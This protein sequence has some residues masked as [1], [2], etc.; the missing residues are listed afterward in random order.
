M[1]IV[2]FALNAIS[3]ITVRGIAHIK[4]DDKTDC[5]LR[6]TRVAIP[7]MK[8]KFHESS[9]PFYFSP[10]GHREIAPSQL[11]PEGDYHVELSLEPL[12]QTVGCE[13]NGNYGRCGHVFAATPISWSDSST[14]PSQDPS[15]L[16][17]RLPP[18]AVKIA[19]FGYKRELLLEASVY[20]ELEH[21]QGVSIPR[22]Y[23]LFEGELE[24]G[25]ERMRRS[26]DLPREFHDL[27]A[28]QYEKLW[29]EKFELA[30]QEL[31]F[32]RTHNGPGG[33]NTVM[34]L[35]LERLGGRLPLGVDL[36]PELRADLHALLE[37]I[38][39]QGVFY[40]D[41]RYFNI[42]QPLPNP[43]G[44]AGIICP[45]HHRRHLWRI[46]DFSHY[47]SKV[48]FTM[49]YMKLVN[50]LNLNKFLDFLEGGEIYEIP[51]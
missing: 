12:N 15:T 27:P 18:L 39:I 28:E 22:F 9:D 4:G 48:A 40:Y 42:L 23:G 10:D 7:N 25:W 51:H 34:L 21:L 50:E 19:R 8:R 11:P 6:M 29:G 5:P 31:R 35:L 2:P 13:E 17:G 43:P 1:P 3:T 16:T 30:T 33:S 44:F 49:E 38:A 37:D 32:N 20:K 26:S 41:I 36:G 24:E 46:I 14:S 47:V 45:Y